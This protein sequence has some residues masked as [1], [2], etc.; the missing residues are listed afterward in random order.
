MK[1]NYLSA[2]GI[3]LGLLLAATAAFATQLGLDRNS[4]WGIGR[5]VL[6]SIGLLLA[7]ACALILYAKRLWGVMPA[8]IRKQLDAAW[9]HRVEFA[10]AVCV[11][12]SLVV[13]VFI[14]SAGTWTNWPEVTRYYDRLG[15]AFRQGHLYLDVS[16]AAGLLAMQNP[17]DPEARASIPD[18]SAFVSNEWDLSLYGGRL[19]VYW[20]PAP[21]ALLAILKFVYAGAVPDQVLVFLF[22]S[23]LLVFSMLL[24]LRLKRRLYAETP[25]WLVMTGVLV[26]AFACPIPWMLNRAQIYEATIAGGQFFLMGGMYFALR[27][28]EQR[29]AARSKLVIAGVFLALAAA[30]RTLM[31]IPAAFLTLMIMLWVA[32]EGGEERLRWNKTLRALMLAL[33]LAVGM[34]VLGWYNWARFGSPFETGL[35]YTL[36]LQDLNRYYGDT[37]SASDIPPN[38]WAY[39]IHPFRL[40]HK[41]PFLLATVSR[42]PEWLNVKATD[43]YSTDEVTGLPFS[44]PFAAL[45]IL[46]IVEAIRSRRGKSNEG[47]AAEDVR[48]RRLLQWVTIGIAGSVVLTFGAILLYFNVTMR[49]LAEFVPA[50]TV[51]SFLGACQ[52][53][54]WLQS[55][56]IGRRWYSVLVVALGLVSIAIS[57]LLALSENLGS[58]QHY[59]PDLMRQWV[60]FFGR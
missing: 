31:L 27:G 47:E 40:W 9:Q 20:G 39:L 35:R 54:Q 56:L 24:I 21:A 45:S 29:P 4:S 42:S 55:R 53:Y 44:V 18:V 26:A 11:L 23:G 58:I 52:G 34:A 33:P 14:V 13:Y 3:L 30:A 36:T 22:L 38:L 46:A 10:A 8:R 7:L 41:F 6:F 37:F 57:L 15:T 32:T 25:D 16:P 19:Y 60:D 48:G 43:I 1:R 28:V 51:L 17:Y 2:A 50:L 59:N 49:F 5:S 12:V